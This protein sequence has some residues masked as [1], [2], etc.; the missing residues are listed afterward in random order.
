MKIDN[1]IIAS[2]N[3]KLYFEFVPYAIKHFKNVFG[4]NVIFNYISDV[5]DLS[6]EIKDSCTVINYPTDNT[7]RISNAVLSKISRL[8]TATKLGSETFMIVDVEQFILNKF[9]PDAIAT[10]DDNK[11]TEI[12]GNM[13]HNTTSQGKTP[14]GYT[15]GKG[16]VFKNI[17]NPNDYDYL[18]LLKTWSD[19][20]DGID[21]KENIT[22]VPNHFSD[23]SLLRYLIVRSGSEDLINH[24]SRS[25]RDFKY[26]FR[27]DRHWSDWNNQAEILDNLKNNYYIDCQPLRPLK[28]NMGKME[29]LLKHLNLK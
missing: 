27:L 13:Y 28:E 5:N 24:I 12:G 22:N 29:N 23:E 2:D 11:I 25:G 19:I 8:I 20:V 1:I 17:V 3:N 9:V 4:C 18:D 15:S 26:D 16:N 14:M 6:E 7:K 10:A 21:G